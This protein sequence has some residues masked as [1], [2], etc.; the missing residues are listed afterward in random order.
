M[1]RKTLDIPVTLRREWFLV[2]LAHLTKNM[3]LKLQLVK[4]MLHRFKRSSYGVKDRER[5]TI[6]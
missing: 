1:K 3:E 6:R 2:E 4:W 5:A